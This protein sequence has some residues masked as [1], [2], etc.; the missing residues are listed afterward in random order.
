MATKPT[1][2]PEIW[3]SATV[4]AS[5]PKTGQPTKAS[6]EAGASVEGHKPG[7]SEPTTANEFNVF[8]HKMSL[9]ARWAFAGRFDKAADAHILE[10]DSTGLLSARAAD[11][12][13]PSEPGPTISFIN[14]ATGWGIDGTIDSGDGMQLRGLFDAAES[15]QLMFVDTD[16]DN[17][18]QLAAVRVRCSNAQSCGGVAIEANAQ[19]T[20]S[21]EDL[22]AGLAVSNVGGTGV[23][24]R[25]SG[26]ALP[27]VR[28][29]NQTD[30]AV[31]ARFGHG[32]LEPIGKNLDG[33]AI[34]CR[35][36]DADGTSLAA[37]GGDGAFCQGGAFTISGTEKFAGNGLTAL[38]GLS[39]DAIP[40]GAAVFAQTV[41]NAAIAVEASHNSASATLPVI[42]ATTGGNLANG[43]GVS[44]TGGGAGVSISAEAGS[45]L[46]IVMNPDGG[47][48]GPAVN[49]ETQ[50]RPTTVSVGTLWA[51]QVGAVVNWL[52]GLVGTT[53][54]YI[55][56]VR[57]SPCYARSAEQDPYI[58]S[59]SP[60]DESIDASFTWEPGLVPAET[61][62]V[63]ITIW[64]TVSQDNNSTTSATLKV[65]DKT[66]GGDPTVMTCTVATPD[67]GVAGNSVVS[68]TQSALYTLPASGARTFDLV[69]S[70]DAGLASGNF[71]G[72]VEIQH[73]AGI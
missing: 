30:G 7:P 62:V 6:S 26:T 16:M 24:V 59:G 22:L 57:Q 31:S 49:I 5:G 53:H 60:T 50:T 37:S 13:D 43:I 21:G 41:G 47:V 39:S 72:F 18:G 34:D 15:S 44:C 2:Q 28:V 42:S 25:T 32:N 35:G 9:L 8:E 23:Q 14:S 11:F 58:L 66:V 40:G 19:G 64:G 17:T 1:E 36:G 10:T 3:A 4:Y 70:G 69:W 20:I 65:R 29:L 54:G 73:I 51:E 27:G 33:T 48:I 63:R 55:P 45:G 71:R 68:C 56:R 12:G 52:T 38:S 61:A 46:S 67:F